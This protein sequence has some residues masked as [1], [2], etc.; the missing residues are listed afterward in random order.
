MKKKI[1]A[2]LMTMAMVVTFIPTFAF[3][4][5]GPEG[6]EGVQATTKTPAYSE[7]TV[8]DEEYA[9]IY[10]VYSTN[11]DVKIKGYEGVTYDADTNTMTIDNVNIE[12]MVLQIYEMG[13][14]TVNVIGANKIAEIDVH[15]TNTEEIPTITFAG[16]GT[17]TSNL[18]SVDRENLT[19]ECG[20][21]TVTNNYGLYDEKSEVEEC[22]INV[23][24]FDP[25]DM[26][27]FDELM[28]FDIDDEVLLDNVV[29]K[30]NC[31]VSVSCKHSFDG[32][33][34]VLVE[35][36]GVPDIQLADGSKFKESG[37]DTRDY[38]YTYK[39]DLYNALTDSRDAGEWT[40]NCTTI[41][42]KGASAKYKSYA[43]DEVDDGQFDYYSEDFAYNK[44][45]S[46]SFNLYQQPYFDEVGRDVYC[47]SEPFINKI[48]KAT[49]T[50]KWSS[51]AKTVAKVDE[52]GN[53]TPLKAGKATITAK[54]DGKKYS[55]KV[56]V[57]KPELSAT[58]LSLE[59][60]G[61]TEALTVT[62][63]TDPTTWTTSSAAIA[64][65]DENGVVKTGDKLGTATITAK[66]NGYKITC[67]VTVVSTYEN[68][69]VFNFGDY[70]TKTE[71]TSAE[72]VDGVQSYTYSKAT[73]ANA[74]AYGKKL[75]AAGF[76]E[77]K[78]GN[79]KPRE[80]TKKRVARVYKMAISDT[81][82]C[83][84][85][86]LWTNDKTMNIQVWDMAN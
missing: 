76:K 70:Y 74:T 45:V 5:E 81:E 39:E 10:R 86:F 24:G 57:M 77:D 30:M 69:P 51:S 71:L 64:T 23:S 52:E 82:T 15:N 41:G 59:K 4:A 80:N 19:L 50:V 12:N 61:T 53:V 1:I 34:G 2:L 31:P 6:D 65:V 40:Y 56:R 20:K 11:P 84:V 62:G 13:D 75:V 85:Y 48:N 43:K 16:E 37:L 66:R 78:S 35:T 28:N 29:L 33:V 18:I 9:N 14:C 7:I 67:K 32:C 3:A 73:S 17:I 54:V 26:P 83:V 63:G 72:T 8:Y 21:V 46:R 27:E 42:K 60:G 79:I 38:S 49:G 47:Y 25:Y 55:Y 44:Y 36:G 68:H 58:K 22:C